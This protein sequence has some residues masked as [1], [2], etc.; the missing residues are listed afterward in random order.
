MATTTEDA[1]TDQLPPAYTP[2]PPGLQQVSDN[3]VACLCHARYPAL[4]SAV[5]DLAAK[6]HAMPAAQKDTVWWGCA[7]GNINNLLGIAH[8]P[9]SCCDE[10]AGPSCICH[11]EYSLMRERITALLLVLKLQKD[12]IYERNMMTAIYEKYRSDIKLLEGMCRQCMRDGDG[13]KKQVHQC[14]IM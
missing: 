2:T 13:D 3:K 5:E 6:Y 1:K 10:V 4:I 14:V 9:G 8:T 7:I 11:D 12:D